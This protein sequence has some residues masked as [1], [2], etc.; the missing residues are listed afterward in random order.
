M[1]SAFIRGRKEGEKGW[2]QEQ[3]DAFNLENKAS[4]ESGKT[5]G[6]ATNLYALNHFVVSPGTSPDPVPGAGPAVPHE[7]RLEAGMPDAT[8][9][10]SYSELVN[11]NGIQVDNFVSHYWGHPFQDTLASLN[12]WSSSVYSSLGK[13]EPEGVVYWLCVLALNQHRAG[14]E[15]GSSPEEGPFN[16]ALMQASAGAVMVVDDNVHPFSRIWCLFEVKRLTDLS[17]DFQLICSLGAMGSLVDTSEGHEANPRL[18][19][20]LRNVGDALMQVHAFDAKSSSEDDKFAIWHRVADPAIRKIP[21]SVA[22]RSGKFHGNAFKRFDMTVRSLLAAPL[23]RATL[24]E[25]DYAGALRYL[26]LGASFGEVELQ[27]FDQHLEGDVCKAEVPVQSGIQI[28]QWKLLHCAAYFGHTEAITGLL[29]RGA[30]I[31]AKTSFGLTALHQAARN[32]HHHI[33]AMLLEQRAKVDAVTKDGRSALQNAAHQGHSD[34]CR[35]LL[36]HEADVNASSPVS[37]GTSP[38]H[39]AAETGQAEVVEVLIAFRADARRRSRTDMTP[40]HAAASAGFAEVVKSMIQ[41]SPQGHTLASLPS[42]R[43]SALD[44]AEKEGHEEVA[45]VLRQCSP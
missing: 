26:G 40:L 16:A 42:R 23:L 11:P 21:L 33:C 3:C 22:R 31:E 13:R 35:V 34:V 15:V 44:L 37:G 2:L 19:R 27:L 32:G 6:M 39:S 30:A 5:F 38:L 28:V 18:L 29:V 8:H 1:E 4:I 45:E 41:G 10:S 17:K 14:E 7:L 25:G 12:A 9:Q 43:G 20:T 36:E 24:N